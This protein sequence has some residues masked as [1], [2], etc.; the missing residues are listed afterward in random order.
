MFFPSAL[1]R[2]PKGKRDAME[3]FLTFDD[4]PVPGVTP[5][6]LDI[7][8][9]YG[10]QATFFMVGDNVRRH[11]EL[12]EEVLRRGHQVGNH[13]MHHLQGSQVTT[14]RYLRDI[15]EAHQLI[16]S[17]LFRPPHGWMRPRQS[18]A[19]RKMFYPVMYDLVTRD[20]SWR[21]TPQR[22]IENVQRYARPGAI[23]VFHD[24]EK[25]KPR[26]LEGL[27]KALEW[28]LENGYSFGVLRPEMIRKGDSK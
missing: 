10:A 25:A 17:P 28:L 11:P 26:V 27:P 23:I 13:T 3:V 7:L 2:V 4:G 12:L 14:K 1:F 6:V 8:D 18:R 16:E 5:K 9:H 19:L 22:V 21:L 15:M 24:S 20:Y